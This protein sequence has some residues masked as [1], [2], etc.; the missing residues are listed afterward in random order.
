MRINSR[1]RRN[2]L[3]SL[4][5]WLV[6]VGFPKISEAAPDNIG[7]SDQRSATIDRVQVYLNQ[8]STLQARFM[9][10]APDGSLSEGTL[11]LAR[12]GGRIRLEYAPP[13]QLLVVGSEGWITLRD[14]GADEDSR[15]PVGGTP[16]EVLI[17]DKVDLGRD[18]A[19]R[20]VDKAGGI[21]RLT[22]EGREEPDAGSLTLIFSDSP[23]E[24]RQWQVID[25]QRMLT[26]VTLADIQSNMALDSE[27]FEDDDPTLWGDDEDG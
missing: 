16:F 23:M 10:V 15:W 11:Y 4:L 18:V 24:L 20:Q 1:F 25:A 19:V 9:Q 26:T 5:G 14:R 12:P 2:L 3:L 7:I 21:I 22:V 8:L 27:L 13:S 17:G 6:A